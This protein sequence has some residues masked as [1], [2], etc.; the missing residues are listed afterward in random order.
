MGFFS[1][2]PSFGKVGPVAHHSLGQSDFCFVIVP[3]FV[4]RFTKNEGNFI[5]VQN[6]RPSRPRVVRGPLVK[7]VKVHVVAGLGVP[8]GEVHDGAGEGVVAHHAV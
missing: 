6:S 1:F 4:E 5:P 2:L 8:V 3:G 7:V